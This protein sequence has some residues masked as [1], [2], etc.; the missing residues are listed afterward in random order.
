VAQL[1][2]SAAAVANLHFSD[3]EL[4]QIDQHAVEAGIDLWRTQSDLS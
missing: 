1:E 4:Q 2:D 3:A